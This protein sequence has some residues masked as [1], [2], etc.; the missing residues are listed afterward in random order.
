VLGRNCRFLQSPDTDLSVVAEMRAA[1]DAGREYRGT[2]LNVRGRDRT[3]WWNE[4]HLAPV[5]DGDGRVLQY[6]G[7]QNDVTDRVRAERELL[8]ERDRGRSYLARIER[9]AW[10][11][12]L[13]G[14]PNR[15]RLAEQVELAVW[16]ARA[17]DGALALLFCDLDGFKAVNDQLGHAAGDELLVAV[18]A[19]LT[20]RLRRG[21]LLARLGGDEF[22]VALPGLEPATARAEAEAVAG[23]LAAA[24]AEPLLVA[25]RP[26]GVG[27]SI[28]VSVFP[29]DGEDLDGLLHAADVRMYERKHALR[30]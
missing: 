27:V 2:L 23:Q 4:I 18:A 12:P 7:V 9:M 26:V 21:D 3:P 17:T 1:I 6:I 5:T 15:R 14:L 11:D 28:G 20:A 22:L 19:R 8:E 29:G 25:G 16:D 30:G 13:T 24:V 10:T